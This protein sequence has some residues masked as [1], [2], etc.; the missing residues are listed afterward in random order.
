MDIINF[1]TKTADGDCI[2]D[3]AVEEGNHTGSRKKNHGT[4]CKDTNIS[5]LP[6][7]QQL[8]KSI[9]SL[10]TAGNSS[11][12]SNKFREIEAEAAKSSSMSSLGQ[13]MGKLSTDIRAARKHGEDEEII[14]VMQDELAS[15][16]KLNR[17]FRESS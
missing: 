7:L 11:N 9:S 13:N 6:V 12:E 1:V 4:V 16:M 3:D 8:S 17:R 5:L 10:A 14:R 2:Y 15:M